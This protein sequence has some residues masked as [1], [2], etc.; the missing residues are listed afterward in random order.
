MQLRRSARRPQPTAYGIPMHDKVCLV[1][2]ANRGIGRAIAEGL[3]AAGANVVLVCRDLQ[4]AQE[5]AARIRRRTRNEKVHVM[6]ADLAS[7]GSIRRLAAA[8]TERFGRVDVLVHN[9]GVVPRRRQVSDDGIELQLA[10]NHL[11]PFLLTALL[12]ECLGASA[13]ARVVTVSSDAHRVARL[14]FD[15]LQAERRYGRWSRYA[16]TKL[17]NVLFTY[18]LA[19][20]LEGTGVTANCLHPGV[21]RTGLARDLT[22]LP[23]SLA[24]LL[25]LGY[26]RPARGAATAIHLAVSPKVEGITGQY[27]VRRAPRRSSARSYDRDAQQR[28]W[29][30]SA[31]LIAAG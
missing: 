25:S 12:R 10:V 2:G 27:F 11:A 23:R 6:L 15:D 21:I 18:E 7:G 31:R 16:S 8:Y 28:L 19:R 24:W 30:V 1:T 17:M 3:A 20:R 29:E 22:P 13:P 9:A 14:D 5:A 4:A 26:G